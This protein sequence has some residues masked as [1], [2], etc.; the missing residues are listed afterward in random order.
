MS[1]VRF[2][3]GLFPTEPVEEAI[4]LARLADTLGYDDVWIG[5]SHMIWKELFVLLGACAVRT[6]RVTLG[7]CVTNPVTRHVTVTASAMVTLNQLT[8]GRMKL[9]LGTG[10]SALRNLGMKPVRL[11]VVEETIRTFRKLFAGQAVSLGGHDVKLMFASGEE[12]PI[13]LASNTVK[14]LQTAGRVADGAVMSQAFEDIR[15]KLSHI[16]DGAIEGKRDPNK[17]R[18]MLWTPC[19]VSENA[20]EAREAVKP[21][22]ARR[23]IDRWQQL[24]GEERKAAEKLRQAYDFY[25]HMGP[26]HSALV[27]ES[28]V[29][30]LSIAGSGDHCREKVQELIESGIREISI[31]PWGD[32]RAVIRNFSKEVINKIG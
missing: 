26:E 17:I 10:D 9:G 16:R 1:A 19:C 8:K 7:P 31:V 6:S 20:A 5:D 23:I 30:K 29:D 21:Q 4:E 12:I 3:V 15:T 22:I 11:S 28:L 2:G 27:P 24:E 14:G 32:R 25:H 18:A 13:Y